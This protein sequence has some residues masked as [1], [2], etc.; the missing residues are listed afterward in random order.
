MRLIEE[1]RISDKPTIT[2]LTQEETGNIQ[3][4]QESNNAYQLSSGEYFCHLVNLNELFFERR[5]ERV[6]D[7]DEMKQKLINAYQHRS[8]NKKITEMLQAYGEMS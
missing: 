6:F 2:F 8:K 4:R 7:K 1:F 5:V 3:I